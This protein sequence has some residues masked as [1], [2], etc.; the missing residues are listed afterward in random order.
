MTLKEL[1]TGIV[2][3]QIEGSKLAHKH[4]SLWERDQRRK[5]EKIANVFRGFYKKYPELYELYK[6][7]LK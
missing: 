6:R 5:A 3:S 7:R 2:E 4:E 1:F